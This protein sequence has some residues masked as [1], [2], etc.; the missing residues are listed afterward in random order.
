MSGKLND[1]PIYD[2]ISHLEYALLW[3]IAGMEQSIVLDVEYLCRIQDSREENKAAD[4]PYE[5]KLFAS[6]PS[7]E[8]AYLFEQM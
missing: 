4:V 8:C 2:H 6:Y 3:H 1:E 7:L 5:R